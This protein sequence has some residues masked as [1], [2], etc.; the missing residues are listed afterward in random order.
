MGDELTH[1]DE[2]I[3]E[4]FVLKKEEKIITDH[5]YNGVKQ[6]NPAVSVKEIDS[7]IE[8]KHVFFAK[9]KEQTKRLVNEMPFPIDL[10]KLNRNI[11]EP[12]K[13]SPK[14][15]VDIGHFKSLAKIM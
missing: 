11:E 12:V 14:A 5:N 7:I 1:L 4:E 13:P 9:F 6:L 3:D 2:I 15:K 10:K 8:N